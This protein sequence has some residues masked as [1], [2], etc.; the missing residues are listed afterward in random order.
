LSVLKKLAPGLLIAMPQL[1]D[2]NF[3]HAV[4]LVVEHNDDGAM[5]LILNHTSHL[6]FAQLAQSSSTALQVAEHRKARSLFVGGPV[7]PFRGFVLHNSSAVSERLE[8]LDG[9]YLSVTQEALAPL[10]ASE[11][12]DLR[13]CLG[14]SGWGSG[15]L[16]KEI[17]EGSWLFCEA[18]VAAV[19]FSTPETLWTETLKSM[20][21]EPGWIMAPNLKGGMN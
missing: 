8:V 17:N 14:Y 6:T 15:Q 10:L 21:V 11:A 4:V 9:L 2:D 13:F 19:L 20:G 7:E 1:L 3:K 5:G 16:E 18:S 12:T